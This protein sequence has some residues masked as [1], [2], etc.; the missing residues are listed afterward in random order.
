MEERIG[1][2]RPDMPWIETEFDPEFREW[3][4][5]FNKTR[6]P[7]IMEM[8]AEADC[9]K[10]IFKNRAEADSYLQL[11]AEYKGYPHGNP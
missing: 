4:I 9:E 6:L 7:I 1:Q 11:L 8:L 2:K 3:I 5:N 10:F